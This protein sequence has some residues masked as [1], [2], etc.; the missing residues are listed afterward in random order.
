MTDYTLQALSE[1]LDKLIEHC[2][3]L[4]NDNTSLVQREQQWRKERASLIEKNEQASTR[5]EAMI[6]HLKSLKEGVG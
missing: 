4:R 1:Q 6:H 2:E 3:Q 5:V